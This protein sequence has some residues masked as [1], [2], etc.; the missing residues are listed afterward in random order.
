MPSLLLRRLAAT[1]G[2]ALVVFGSLGAAPAQAEEDDT[3]PWDLTIPVVDLTGAV[4]D[5]VP[6]TMTVR[7]LGPGV[8]EPG[9]VRTAFIQKPT[10]T[11]FTGDVSADCDGTVQPED[12]YYCRPQQGLAVGAEVVWTFHLKL[13]DPHPGEG[14]MFF[15]DGGGEDRDSSNDGGWFKVTIK[16]PET[17]PTTAAPTT[18]AA[19]P[20]GRATAGPGA[21]AA[22][23]PALPVTGDRTGLYAGLGAALVAAGAVLYVLARRRRVVMVTP[24]R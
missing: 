20:T 16:T 1:A 22:A 21:S 24:E 10:G 7:N 6:V 4:G 14:L 9:R 12:R 2:A 17:G 18:A 19:T 8:V 13:V 23:G 11:E 5:V 15:A 3:F